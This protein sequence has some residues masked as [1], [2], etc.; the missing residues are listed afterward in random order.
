MN[1]FYNQIRDHKAKYEDVIINENGYSITHD[2]KLITEIIFMPFNPKGELGEGFF[3][4]HGRGVTDKVLPEIRMLHNDIVLMDSKDIRQNPSLFYKKI[5]QVLSLSGKLTLYYRGTGTL[6]ESWLA[7]I[8]HKKGLQCPH[9]KKVQLDA[10][11]ISI[12]TSL[13]Q[14]LFLYFFKFGT[15]DKSA[16]DYITR[17]SQEPKMQQL[18]E[19]YKLGPYEKQTISS[20]KFKFVKLSDEQI[21]DNFLDQKLIPINAK[22]K[23]GDLLMWA[24]S[25]NRSDLVQK[26]ILSEKFTRESPDSLHHSIQEA[27]EIAESKNLGN[28]LEILRRR[29]ELNSRINYLFL[30]INL[31]CYFARYPKKYP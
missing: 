26:I 4:G 2:N 12:P 13:E 3:S 19:E 18:L 29:R 14:E 1:T 11:N 15:F 5:I 8:H 23:N 25:S 30:L 24:V 20:E 7:Y 22:N 28:V 17:L 31:F 10:I 27:V 21:I 6:V 16:Q 9:L